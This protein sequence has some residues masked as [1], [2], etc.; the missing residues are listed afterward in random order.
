MTRRPLLLLVTITESA[1]RIV[2]LVRSCNSDWVMVETL[3][4]EAANAA[5]FRV[6]QVRLTPEE[7]ALLGAVELPIE[8]E[9]K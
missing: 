7:F 4:R 8:G 2:R 5:E 6:K 3:T 9:V 1:S